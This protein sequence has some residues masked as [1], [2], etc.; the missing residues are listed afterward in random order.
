MAVLGGETAVVQHNVLAIHG[1]EIGLGHRPGRR[2]QH[3]RARVQH[4]V[5]AAV[6]C[7]L[8]G[9]G[10]DPAAEGDRQG[11][12]APG[13][14][15]PLEGGIPLDRLD[16]DVRL[17]LLRGGVGTQGHRGEQHGHTGPR[18]QHPGKGFALV[19]HNVCQ[20]FF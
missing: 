8:A 9:D 5:N 20:P 11:D 2:R 10:M 6:V 1:G 14:H 7:G 17:G 12:A 3:R 16:G 19:I 13:L 18:R 15:G 4:D